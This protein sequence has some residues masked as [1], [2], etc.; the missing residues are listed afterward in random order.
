MNAEEPL[1]LLRI[2]KGR[3]GGDNEKRGYIIDI[4][5]PLFWTRIVIVLRL[6]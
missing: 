2:T 4:L 1:L 3:G 6:I 5:G